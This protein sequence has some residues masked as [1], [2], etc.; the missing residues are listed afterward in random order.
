[1][2]SEPTVYNT[3]TVYDKAGDALLMSDGGTEYKVKFEYVSEA[4]NG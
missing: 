3:R 2:V 4:Q 1:M